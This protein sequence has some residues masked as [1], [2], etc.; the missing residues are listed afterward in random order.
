[1]NAEGGRRAVGFAFGPQHG[2]QRFTV[3]FLCADG[4]IFALCPVAPF[5]AAVPSSTACSLAESADASR[6]LAHSATTDA[7]L[8]QVGHL[9]C[10]YQCSMITCYHANAKDQFSQSLLQ[11]YRAYRPCSHAHSQGR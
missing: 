4:D 9:L 3:Y 8:Q 11:S 2:W 5:S 6:D 10:P 1:M 7:W